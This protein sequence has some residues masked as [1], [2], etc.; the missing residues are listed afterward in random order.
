L[1]P[2]AVGVCTI[3]APALFGSSFGA[4]LKAITDA[5]SP[6]PAAAEFDPARDLTRVY[7]G[8]YSMQGVDIAGIAVGRFKPEKIAAAADVN[9]RTPTGA[10][11]AKSEYAGRTLYTSKGIGFTVLTERTVLFGN[12]TGIRRALDR[13]QEGRAKRQLPKWMANMLDKPSAPLVGGADFTSQPLPAAAREQVAFVDG[14][15]TASIVGNFADPGLNLA[16]TLNYAEADAAQRG[17]DNLKQLHGRLSTFGPVMA[18][19]GIPQPVRSLE[20]RAED[21]DVK[22]TAGVDGAA[23]VVLLEKA[24]SYLAPMAQ[25]Q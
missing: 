4:R 3:D 13:I 10:P 21:K 20:A 22:F 2:N 6:L 5:R 15:K 9:L 8:I 7:L 11:V 17:A 1:P 12:E 14:L 19:L 23:I 25:G 18:L 16:G 24:E